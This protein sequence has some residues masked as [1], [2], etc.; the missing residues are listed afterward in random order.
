MF[1]KHLF[2]LLLVSIAFVGK[3]GCDAFVTHHLQYQRLGELL[4]LSK[5]SEAESLMIGSRRSL[6]QTTLS[7]L[8]VAPVILQSTAVS[9]AT[10][11]PLSDVLYRIMRVREA[12]Q[13]ETRLIKTGKF[14]DVQRANVKLAVKFMVD[15]YRL[16]DAF[17]TASSYLEGS[18]SRR[19]EA[20]QVGQTAVQNLYTI[21]EYFDSADVQN[22]KVGQ[23]S[24]MSGKEELVFK[25]LDATRRSIDDFL[26]YFPK[27]EVDAVLSK[28][29]EE[30]ELNAKEFDSSFGVILNMPPP[31]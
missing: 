5:T 21:L 10:R 1:T 27:V 29:K 31:S 25:G 14:K 6:L 9:A 16:N 22:L 18:D 15:N 2:T 23:M 11:E 12:T 20:S 13:Q 24:A 19:V 4:S 28:I 8:A 7:A 30:N 26:A 17:V 3:H